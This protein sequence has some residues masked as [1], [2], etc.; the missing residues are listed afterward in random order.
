LKTFLQILFGVVLGAGGLAIAFA[1]MVSLKTGPATAF[2]YVLFF[3]VL[4]WV[5][6]VSFRRE[7]AQQ[8]F[9][10]SILCLGAAF[11]VL[12]YNAPTV[13]EQ[14]DQFDVYSVLWRSALALLCVLA[15]PRLAS[16]LALR[17]L[18]SFHQP[19]IGIE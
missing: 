12:R 10:S 5:L 13:W 11:W 4:R 16:N 1:M 17:S 7:T 18:R 15:I 9:V 14:E 6:T 8:L 3:V 2:A 19:S